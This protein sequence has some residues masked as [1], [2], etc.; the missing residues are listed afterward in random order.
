MNRLQEE[1]VAKNITIIDSNNPLL[2]ASHFDEP[3]H[4]IFRFK[5]KD[6]DF[7]DGE[8]M[9]RELGAYYIPPS[10]QVMFEEEVRQAKQRILAR[11]NLE[12]FKTTV[13]TETSPNIEPLK[14]CFED[15]VFLTFFY[16]TF[17]IL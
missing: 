1:M 5:V 4:A 17:I 14:V 15:T 10:N 8:E 2:S 11:R 6:P 12:H 16:I 7:V 9:S 13:K 3:Y